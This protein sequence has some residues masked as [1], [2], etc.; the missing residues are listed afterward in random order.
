MWDSGVLLHP[1]SFTSVSLVCYY[2]IMNAVQIQFW[3]LLIGTIFAWYNTSLEII[4]WSR[5]KKCK[6]GCPVNAKNPFLSPCIYGAL[7]FTAAFVLN[8]LI[9]TG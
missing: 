5:G 8:L 2:E 7:F 1:N 9:K 3:V 6:R 4:D